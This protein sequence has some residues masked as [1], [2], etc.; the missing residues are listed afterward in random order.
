MKGKI[1]KSIYYWIVLGG[2]LSTL[3]QG[4]G[5]VFQSD[6]K[7]NHSGSVSNNNQEHVADQDNG[8]QEG[9]AVVGEGSNLGIACVDSEAISATKAFALTQEQY[10]NSLIDLFG[11]SLVS[12]VSEKINALPPEV[13]D[14]NNRERLSSFSATRATSYNDI[15]QALSKAVVAN[16]TAFLKLFGTCAS[17]TSPSANCINTYLKN[18]ATKILR[19][20]LTSDEMAAATSLFNRASSFKDGAQ[21]VLSYH[22]QSP[23]FL[24]RVE[25]G[26]DRIVGGK[27][28]LTNYEIASR[29]SYNITNSMPD[30]ELFAAAQKGELTDKVNLKNQVLR[31]L[32]STRGKEKVIDNLVAYAKADRI[33]SFDSLPAEVLNGMDP[34]KL[35]D[36]INTEMRR[37]IDYIVF[38]Q[39]GNFRDLITSRA[40]FAKSRDLASVYNHPVAT[41]NTPVQITERRQGLLMRAGFFVYS[42]PRSHIIHRGALFQKN[43]LCQ[44]IPSPSVAII[45]SRNEFIPSEAEA[46]NMT[47]REI[48]HQRT[49]SIS[50]MGCHSMINSTGFA[51]E[52]FDSIG[53]LRSSE[54]IFDTSKKF[55][56]TLA[57]DTNTQIPLPNT[58][59]LPVTDAYDL[60]SYVADSITGPACFSKNVFRLY[61]EKVESEA[62]GCQLN[63]FLTA[64]SDPSQ[65]ILS[66][67]ANML[68][69]NNEMYRSIE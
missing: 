18:S 15:A 43:I 37:F 48:V 26:E 51:F 38:E 64:S 56:K 50:C 19:R 45:N 68:S 59:A 41:Q 25:L 24:R 29:I 40:S 3:Y 54:M 14:A 27:I 46:L 53:R 63:V 33:S 35:R 6:F 55:V 36:D 13:Y 22:L 23:Y 17:A 30:D 11:S 1:K 8:G 7:S 57:V 60:V 21:Y 10:R 9:D 67:L 62:D 47:N 28:P 32:N 5:N 4:C 39:N 42:Q 20:P 31:L 52:N 34:T 16:S 69:S 65:S 12:Q 58:N 2:F 61:Q 49:D 44:S 66:A